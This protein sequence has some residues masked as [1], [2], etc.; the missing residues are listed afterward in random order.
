MPPMQP[1]N[2]ESERDEATRRAAEC[3]ISRSC[4][5]VKQIPRNHLAQTLEVISDAALDLT[6]LS[7]LSSTGLLALLFLYSRVRPT[8]GLIY[9]EVKEILTVVP[10]IRSPSAGTLPAFVHPR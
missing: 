1:V 8:P 5:Y 9:A 3:F 7:E 6:Y 4:T 10:R 2:G